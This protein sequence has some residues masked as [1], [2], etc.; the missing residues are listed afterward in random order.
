VFDSIVD[1]YKSAVDLSI[2]RGGGLDPLPSELRA[3]PAIFANKRS[4]KLGT[5]ICSARARTVRPTG[6]DRP[7]RGPSGLRAGPSAPHF[8]AQQDASQKPYSP[9]P[10]AGSRR[11]RVPETCSPDRRCTSAVGMK[12]TGRRLSCEERR[13]RNWDDLDAGCRAPFI[14][15]SPRPP[16]LSAHENLAFSWDFIAIG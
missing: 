7:D 9:S 8:G 1:D 11:R 5:L 14:G 3:N 15:P 13:K 12:R 10:G 16:I 4:K 2:Y 6:A